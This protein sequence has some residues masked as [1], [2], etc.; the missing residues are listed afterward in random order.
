MEPMPE[1]PTTL[2]LPAPPPPEQDDP[3]APGQLQP[4]FTTAFW[5]GWMGVAGGFAAVWYSSRT[6]GFSTWWLGPESEPRPFIISL[7]PFVAPLALAVMALR[8]RPWLPFLGMLG[9]LITA[10]VATLDIGRSARYS[11]VEFLLATGGLL[12]SAACLSGMYRSR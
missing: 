12:V 7:L 4:F 1:A 8:H 6:L 10:L 11:L 2:R 9:A 3:P 5:V